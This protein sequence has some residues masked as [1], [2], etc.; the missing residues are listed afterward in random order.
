M[1]LSYKQIEEIADATMHD[2]NEFFFGTGPEADEIRATPIDQFASEYL[3]LRVRIERLCM[4]ESICGIT[5][6]TDTTLL[7][8]MNGVSV[9]VPIKQ[10]EVLLNIHFMQP[11]NIRKLCGQRRFTLAH[12]C[13]HQLLFQLAS[14]KRKAACRRMY[15]GKN[16][17]TARELKTK[18]DW[19]EWQANALGAA[20]LMPRSSFK[21]VA[22]YLL[23]GRRIHSKTG[24]LN[25]FGTTIVNELADCFHVSPRAA[26]I[27]LGHLGYIDE[28]GEESSCYPREEVVL[29]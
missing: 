17:Y 23:R 7:A 5:A 9:P 6:Y 19:D 25:W 21:T 20:I 12:E 18:E 3:K 8:D 16:G 27:R 13:A 26:Q 2:F 22:D 10:N 11:G 28:Y 4:D 14:D 1:I 29:G 15:K 24:E